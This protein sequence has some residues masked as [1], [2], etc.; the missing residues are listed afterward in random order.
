L[1]PHLQS[2]P[3]CNNIARPFR[4]IRPPPTPRLYAIHHT[5]LAMAISFKGQL[6]FRRGTPPVSCLFSHL[7]IYLFTPNRLA[8]TRPTLRRASATLKCPLSIYSHL[9][10]SSVVK[11]VWAVFV[12]GFGVMFLSCVCVSGCCFLSV[13]VCDL[14]I[15]LHHMHI[16]L[17]LTR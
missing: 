2:L 13:C 6:V 7:C 16:P 12:W 14:L 5:V 3:Y 8:F 10:P 9:T 4:N 15:C 17:G 1:P 11:C